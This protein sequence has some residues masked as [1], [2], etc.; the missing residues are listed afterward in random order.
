MKEKL[1]KLPALKDKDVVR[2]LN[3]VGGYIVGGYVRDSLIGR[4]SKDIDICSPRLPDEIESNLIS[5]GYKFDFVGKSYG[6]FLVRVREDLK[7][8]V[9]AAR[10]DVSCDGRHA[11]VKFVNDIQE[12]LARRDL[13]INAIAVDVHGNVVDPFGGQRDLEAGV[14]RFVGVPADRILEDNLRVW[15]ALRFASKLGF[16]LEK[17][18]AQAIYDY[19]C[20][21]IYWGEK[22]KVSEERISSE[23]SQILVHLDNNKYIDE[24]WTLLNPLLET[25]GLPIL[26]TIGCTQPKQWHSFD[27]NIHILKVILHSPKELKSRLAA[28][29]HDIGKPLVRKVDEET[30]KVTFHGHDEVSAEIAEQWLRSMKFSNDVTEDVVELVRYHMM[31]IL[32]NQSLS[33][34]N[35]VKYVRKF[36]SVENFKRVRDL[37]IADICGRDDEPNEEYVNHAKGITS[38]CLEAINNQPLKLAIS[39]YD[40]MDLFGIKEGK[41]VGKY[42]RICIDLVAENPVNNNREFLINFLT[43]NYK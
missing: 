25:T 31:H 19:A 12:D 35:C 28:L 43:E 21:I 27:V 39:G 29:L 13:T 14:V 41:E 3:C 17:K 7:I 11:E 33:N 36:N 37:R 26:K 23:L 32:H 6:V 38:K 9:A 4:E 8:E 10:Y 30:G 40:V 42:M 22:Q 5:G 24:I 18:T 34:K 15:R 2:L 1:A 20:E 16:R